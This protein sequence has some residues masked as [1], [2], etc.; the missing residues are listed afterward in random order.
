LQIDLIHESKLGVIYPN[1]FSETVTINYEIAES[2]QNHEKV[3]IRIY[4]LSGRLV[5]TLVNKTMQPGL[6]KVDWSGN[7]D[8]GGPAPYGTYFVI[9][10]AGKI[11][12][13]REIMLLR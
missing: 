2:D 5:G 8:Q 6:Y 3:L 11:V 12:E 7:Y 1:P 10:R 9:F 4:D 13:V